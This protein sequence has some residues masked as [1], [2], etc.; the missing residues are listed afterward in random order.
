MTKKGRQK[1]CGTNE[2]YFLGHR[3]SSLAP[4]IQQPLHATVSVYVCMPFG[5]VHISTCVRVCLCIICIHDYNCVFI[6]IY[7]AIYIAL[8]ESHYGGKYTHPTDLKRSNFD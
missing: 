5:C 7:M 1:F 3:R 2:K 8:P 6:C 4:G